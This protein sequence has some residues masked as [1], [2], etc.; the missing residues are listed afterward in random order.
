MREHTSWLDARFFEGAGGQNLSELQQKLANSKQEQACRERSICWWSTDAN[1]DQGAHEILY[2]QRL[3]SLASGNPPYTFTALCS[4]S[5]PDTSYSLQLGQMGEGS[6]TCLDFHN[7]G[8]ACKHLCAF[9]LVIDGWASRGLC[10]PFH[11]PSSPSTAREITQ[12]SLESERCVG[13][14]APGAPLAIPLK[15]DVLEQWVNL[16]AAAQDRTVFRGLDEEEEQMA[17]SFGHDDEEEQQ[18]QASDYLELPD[19]FTEQRDAVDTQIGHRIA[20]EV[21]SLLP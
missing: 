13:E 8:G 6:C 10:S 16:Q 14:A 15:D 19:I 17:V 2:L 5:H 9:R 7:K 11:Y 12:R 4:S 18:S 20:E 3:H 1:R 21:S